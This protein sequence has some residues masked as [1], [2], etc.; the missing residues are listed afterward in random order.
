MNSKDRNDAENLH[1]DVESNFTKQMYL[2]PEHT[3]KMYAE[4]IHA[5]N[6]FRE[7]YA[8]YIAGF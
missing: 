5:I 3:K 1:S 4:H 7:P 6:K 8:D 2:V